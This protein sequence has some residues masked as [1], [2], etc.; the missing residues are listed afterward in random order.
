MDFCTCKTVKEVRCSDSKLE[1]FQYVNILYVKNLY[2]AIFKYIIFGNNLC[3]QN[4]AVNCAESYKGLQLDIVSQ[5]FQIEYKF[6]AVNSSSFETIST[7]SIALTVEVRDILPITII[8]PFFIFKISYFL[9][10]Y[11][12]KIMYFYLFRVACLGTITVVCPQIPS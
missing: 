6:V 7:V 8:Y 11:P 4:T 5:S 9:F 12:C 2:F 1:F 10:L 3:E